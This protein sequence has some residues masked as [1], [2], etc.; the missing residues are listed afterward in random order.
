MRLA[1]AESTEN[2]S[3]TDANETANS[4]DNSTSNETDSANRTS[5]DTD[6][7]SIEHIY[8]YYRAVKQPP[9]KKSDDDEEPLYEPRA[10]KGETSRMS[11]SDDKPYNLK[12]IKETSKKEIK[13]KYGFGDKKYWVA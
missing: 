7:L 9:K 12:P 4:T 11:R 8:P 2:N 5:N 6:S 13:E 3:T 1:D 10:T